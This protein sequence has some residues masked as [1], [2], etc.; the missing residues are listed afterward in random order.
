MTVKGSASAKAKI[1]RSKAVT[2]VKAKVKITQKA[3]GRTITL[4]SASATIELSK[5]L[6]DLSPCADVKADGGPFLVRGRLCLRGD[7]LCFEKGVVHVEFRGKKHK[8]A[9][10]AKECVSVS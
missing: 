1:V 2:T 7:R 6:S 3:L 10:I 5:K 9:T 8:I 4:L